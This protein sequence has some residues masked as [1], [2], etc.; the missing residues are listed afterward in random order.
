MHLPSQTTSS[1]VNIPNLQMC[2]AFHLNLVDGRQ[3]PEGCPAL[4]TACASCQPAPAWRTRHHA[5]P[6]RHQPLATHS[7]PATSPLLPPQQMSCSWPCSSHS[8]TLLSLAR[9]RASRSACGH[10]EETHTRTRQRGRG[11][12]QAVAGTRTDPTTL[13]QRCPPPKQHP[14]LICIPPA[15]QQ[16]GTAVQ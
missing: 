16:L 5:C 4:R 12:G 3:P 13:E 6:L 14:R 7:P 10:K 1:L 15:C 2:K 9:M 11:H 8:T